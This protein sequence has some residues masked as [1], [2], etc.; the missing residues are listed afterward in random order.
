MSTKGQ[1]FSTDFILSA[2]VFV[3]I[4]NVAYLMWTHAH[5]QQD[6]LT[7]EKVMQQESYY[8]ASLLVR[9]PGYP[10]DWTA[11][12]V[13]ILGLA[14]PDH[15]LQDAKMDELDL[16]T[17]DDIR[18]ALGL[19]S[20]MNIVIN[21]T[22]ETSTMHVDGRDLVWGTAPVDA[23]TV[24]TAKRSVLVNATALYQRGTVEVVLWQ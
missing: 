7:A 21:V 10:P 17:D 16:M 18:S 3:I 14:D 15:V 22:N 4:L 19:S 24:S 20:T 8:I 2:F 1:V 12:N 23:D 11:G 9:T 5:E 13:D 6:Q